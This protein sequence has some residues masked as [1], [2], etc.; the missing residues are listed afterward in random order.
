MG[1]LVELVV[2]FSGRVSGKD[3][4]LLVRIADVDTDRSL[5][6]LPTVLV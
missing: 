4:P 1:L 3:L 6:F 2:G 5:C